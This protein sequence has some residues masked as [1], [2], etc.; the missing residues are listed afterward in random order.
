MAGENVEN[1]IGGVDA[2][3]QGLGTGPFDSRQTIAE[4]R[5]QNIDHLSIAV[6]SAGK[7]APHP[8]HTAGDRTRAGQT[9]TK[10]GLT[11]GHLKFNPD[12]HHLDGRDQHSRHTEFCKPRHKPLL[13]LGAARL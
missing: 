3:A 8:L 6:V 10:G 1:D 9:S 7:L 11:L 5:S 4:H 12:L 13:V 2:M